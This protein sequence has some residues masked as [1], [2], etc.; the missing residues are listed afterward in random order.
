MAA[1]PAI[2]P[3][4]RE[5]HPRGWT[6]TSEA[7]AEP[8]DPVGTPRGGAAPWRASGHRGGG[9]GPSRTGSSASAHP[10]V[11]SVVDTGMTAGIIM[12][13]CIERR[14]CC[15]TIC[16]WRPGPER[17]ARACLWPNWSAEDSSNSSVEARVP[18]PRPTHFFRTTPPSPAGSAIS[19]RTT[20]NT[21]TARGGADDLRGYRSVRRQV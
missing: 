13:L 9:P 1:P 11:G 3:P 8:S 18:L 6:L 10:C 19:P 20:T 16:W 2:A 17:E 15:L 12:A 14:S 21:F 4:S 5:V 7:F